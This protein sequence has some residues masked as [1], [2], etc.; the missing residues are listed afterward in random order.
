MATFRDLVVGAIVDSGTGGGHEV[1]A[2]FTLSSPDSGMSALVRRTAN[3]VAE[4]WRFVQEENDLWA[5]LRKDLTVELTAATASYTPVAILGADRPLRRWR[6]DVEWYIREEN[7]EGAVTFS[8]TLAEI[9]YDQWRFRNRRLTGRANSRPINYAI[10]PDL[11]VHFDPTPDKAYDVD[12]SYV[13]GVLEMDASTDEPTD[14]PAEFHQLIK[15]NAI[16][17][18]H[19]FDE[20]DESFGWARQQYANYFNNMKRTYLPPPALAPA[21]GS[22]STRTSSFGG[23]TFGFRG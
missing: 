12:L 8:G 19:G 14:L 20:A 15:W 3:F 13:R 1:P 22:G 2:S 16:M 23:D 21:I 7:D 6:P 10:G 18:I 17:M 4:S 5:W 11:Q 9:S